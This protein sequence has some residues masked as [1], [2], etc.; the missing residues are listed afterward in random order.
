MQYI[1]LQLIDIVHVY[2]DRLYY[3]LESKS[4]LKLKIYTVLV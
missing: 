2:L 1:V 3:R 4:Q